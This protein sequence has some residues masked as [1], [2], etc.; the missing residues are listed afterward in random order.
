MTKAT[1]T[2]I[3]ER[4]IALAPFENIKLT[5]GETRDV[6]A[7]ISTSEHRKEL[8][9]ELMQEIEDFVTENEPPK[10]KRKKKKKSSNCDASEID[11]Y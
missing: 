11:I 5:V 7:G 3:I 10:P 6:S 1:I 9:E 8:M 4:T 2:V